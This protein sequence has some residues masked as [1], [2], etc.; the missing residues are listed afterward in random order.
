MD[1]DIEKG[2]KQSWIWKKIQNFVFIIA[3]KQKI[4]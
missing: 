4:A 1:K 2:T 3:K